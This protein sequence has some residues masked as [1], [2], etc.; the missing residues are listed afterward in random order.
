MGL[1]ENN[2]LWIVRVVLGVGVVVFLWAMF[3][4][5][6]RGRS[7][8]RKCRYRMEGTPEAD[9]GM[10]TCPECG[11]K[12]KNTRALRYTRRRWRI[13]LL[14]LT[15]VLLGGYMANYHWRF[16][17]RGW[18]GYVPT[19]ALII[20]PPNTKF[21]FVEGAY[22]ATPFEDR[23][24]DSW[25]VS[26]ILFDELQ[27]RTV[28][29]GLWL[30]QERL[31]VAA[32]KWAAPEVDSDGRSWRFISTVDF[33]ERSWKRHRCD[34][35]CKGVVCGTGDRID[36]P[37]ENAKQL[38]VGYESRSNMVIERAVELG[39][40][41]TGQ[42][43]DGP[44][45]SWSNGLIDFDPWSWGEHSSFAPFFADERGTDLVN[46]GMEALRMEVGWSPTIGRT[47]AEDIP[48]PYEGENCL[49]RRFDLEPIFQR[50][51]VTIS[52][53]IDDFDE[54][55]IM[56]W[57]LDRT[58]ADLSGW[59]GDEPLFPVFLVT[60]KKELFIASTQEGLDKITQRLQEFY[61]N[62]Y[63]KFWRDLPED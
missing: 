61:D 56:D 53:T 9:D 43:A 11:R 18:M 49:L 47:N 40:V 34:S 17:E 8:C 26:P 63:P 45:P 4:D 31:Y 15:F 14:A 39:E 3:W 12:H 5:R 60:M 46:T 25:P 38:M 32:L 30:W 41:I 1:I 35:W 42:W 23:L 59:N 19:T 21:W 24:S 57:I 51:E 52:G 10:I 16:R 22:F 54:R 48:V 62:T 58:I 2:L 55:D 6:A 29:V 44:T 27:Y 20:W 13:A 36:C 28:D 33:S 7:R 50:S 37:G